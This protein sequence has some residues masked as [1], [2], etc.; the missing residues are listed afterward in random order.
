MGVV[1]AQVLVIGSDETNDAL[2][3]FVADIDTDKHSFL[4]DLFSEAH[5]PEVTT[6]LSVDLS[7]DVHV[8]PVVV[9]VDGL[10]GN[11]LRDHGV[12]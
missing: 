11:E 2:L 4:G 6:E 10:A 12:V 1:L 5:S 3:S 9:S 7:D 8:D